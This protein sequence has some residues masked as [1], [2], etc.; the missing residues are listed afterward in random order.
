MLPVLPHP[1]T[2][3]SAHPFSLPASL[4]SC[5]STINSKLDSWSRHRS[6]TSTTA[7][8]YSVPT[9]VTNL[10]NSE[11]HSPQQQYGSASHVRTPGSLAHCLSPKV[12]LCIAIPW[13]KSH[14]P[15][16]TIRLPA[17][18]PVTKWSKVTIYTPWIRLRRRSS[19]PPRA[20]GLRSPGSLRSSSSSRCPQPHD[21]SLNGTALLPS[22]GT[23]SATTQDP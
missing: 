10:W 16:K 13:Q 5:A 15:Y 21:E 3:G 17:L 8:P 18:V 12:I 4:G 14:P 22:R 11:A 20:N 19:S 2:A 9:T 23:A 6:A 1:L 7:I